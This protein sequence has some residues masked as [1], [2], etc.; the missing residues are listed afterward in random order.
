M[1][2]RLSLAVCSLLFASVAFAQP[3]VPAV[4]T[5]VDVLVL[6]ATGDPLTVAPIATR[7]TP[8]GVATLCN[9]AASTPDASPIT[10]PRS[11]EFTDP[12]TAGRVCRVPMPT[13][14]PVGTGYRAVA[15]L[16]APTCSPDGVTAVTPCRSLR[17][18]VG[19]PPFS[20]A[21]ILTLPVTPTNLVIFRLD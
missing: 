8:I 16:V 2:R 19:T 11:M 21:P 13:G 3:T 18:A 6:P 5:S 17:S 7:N 15:L 10:N 20:V 12:F 14:L 4:P 9:L 1:I